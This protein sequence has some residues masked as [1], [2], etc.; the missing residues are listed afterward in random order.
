MSSPRIASRRVVHALRP[1]LDPDVTDVAAEEHAAEET[2]AIDALIDQAER[3]WA[4]AART[5]TAR[6]S[7][8]FT[9]QPR[10]RRA[11]RRTDRTVLRTLPDLLRPL[12]A[13]AG[14]AKAVNHTVRG[15]PIRCPNTGTDQC[16]SGLGCPSC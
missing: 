15:L 9:D 11:H 2:A 10:A 7:R 12:G 8:M 5:E 16:D 4:A 1:Q 13:P 14:F 6:I 3:E